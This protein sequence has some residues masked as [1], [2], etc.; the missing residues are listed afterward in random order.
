MEAHAER[1]LPNECCGLLGG[2]GDLF[3]DYYPLANRA[4][5]PAKGFFAAP[6]DLTAALLR[7]RSG[8]KS[9]LGIHHSHPTT[10]AY[11]S[12]TD[13][14]TALYPEAINFISSLSPKREL[15]AF[16]IKRATVDTVD[17]I[18]VE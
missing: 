5:D 1:S 13:I 9:L 11:P 8:G 16:H 3:T 10:A 17:F 7:M 4:E 12:T 6:E 14:K 2:R 18:I 15:R